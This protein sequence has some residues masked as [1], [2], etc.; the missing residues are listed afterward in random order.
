MTCVSWYGR[1][2]GAK[3]LS[4][5]LTYVSTLFNWRSGEEGSSQNGKDVSLGRNLR[6][7]REMGDPATVPRVR[8][9]WSSPRRGTW[10]KPPIAAEVLRNVLS[11]QNNVKMEIFNDARPRL[12]HGQ[13]HTRSHDNYELLLMFILC[14]LHPVYANP[15]KKYQVVSVLPTIAPSRCASF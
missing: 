1:M 11:W 7:C 8:G 15:H 4:F 10:C 12:L 14:C 13:G 6:W 3:G 9:E 2:V 5:I